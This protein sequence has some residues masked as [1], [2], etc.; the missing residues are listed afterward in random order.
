MKASFF[1]YRLSERIS[2]LIPRWAAYRLGLV[3]S[4]WVYLMSTSE[5]RDVKEN[6]KI[7]MG[8]RTPSSSLQTMTRNVYEKFSRNCVDLLYDGHNGNLADKQLITFE[9]LNYLEESMSLGRGVILL[10]AHWGNWELGAMVLGV[11]RYPISVVVNSHPDE[12]INQLFVQRRKSYGVGVIPRGSAIRRCVQSLQ[13]GE[14]VGLTGDRL[15]DQDGLRVKVFDK[16]TLLPKGP[17][18]L[19]RKTNAPI[20]GCAFGPN[21]NQKG[22]NFSFCEPLYP[23]HFDADDRLSQ[24]IASLVESLIRK[25]PL[26][27]FCFERFWNHSMSFSPMGLARLRRSL[28]V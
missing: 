7:V 20:I 5:R 17:M 18:Y 16:S 6:L 27:W 10:T 1:W 26:Q 24:R 2:R 15:Y 19:S 13:R 14:I 12:R 28:K 22:F 21:T 4:W 11:R 3:C 8:A 23:D 25:D 9:N